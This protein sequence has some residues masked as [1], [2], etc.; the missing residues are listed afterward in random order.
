MLKSFGYK[1]EAFSKYYSASHPKDLGQIKEAC[2][3]IQVQLVEFFSTAVT[4]MRG[5]RNF[6]R[7]CENQ[8]T[9]DAV[10]IQLIID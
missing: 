7:P 6:S 4:A 8:H 2:F 10:V 1:T 3:E 5:E 9:Q